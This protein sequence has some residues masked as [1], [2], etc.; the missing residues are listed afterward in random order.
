M[1]SPLNAPLNSACD[2]FLG[3]EQ[4]SQ[5]LHFKSFFLFYS[6]ISSI[7]SNLYLGGR[8]SFKVFGSGI[9]LDYIFAPAFVK[10]PPPDPFLDAAFKIFH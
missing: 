9:Q 1:P 4:S 10:T 7:A 5:K 3:A 2:L 8:F 6:R